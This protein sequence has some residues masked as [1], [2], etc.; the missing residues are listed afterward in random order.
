MLNDIDIEFKYDYTQI[1]YEYFV[2]K[3]RFPSDENKDQN[4]IIDTKKT[5]TTEEI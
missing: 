2:L 4:I 3:G 5:L 1:V